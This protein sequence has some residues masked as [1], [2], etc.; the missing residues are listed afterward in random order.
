MA[1]TLDFDASIEKISAKIQSTQNGL[2][3]MSEDYRKVGEASNAAIK[4]AVN[5]QDALGS[6]TVQAG[7]KLK[8]QAGIIEKLEDHLKRL[9][10]GQRKAQ[11][12]PA[13]RKYNTEIA[14][15][16][17]ALASLRG[18]STAGFGAAQAGANAAKVAASTLGTTLRTAFAPLLAVTAATEG[19]RQIISLVTEYEQVAADLSAVTG[20]NGD[21]LEFLKQSAVEVGTETTISAAKTLKAYEL[22][23][24]AKPELLC[25][26]S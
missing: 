5:D 22:I 3:G 11:D 19:I 12:I 16:R 20:A 15:T 23:A 18:A 17:A 26:R 13:I 14:K 8:D 1:V 2:R 7:K 24:S 10:I 21:T 25:N 4:K 6:S 9:E